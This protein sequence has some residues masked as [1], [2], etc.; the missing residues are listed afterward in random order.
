MFSKKQVQKT[1]DLSFSKS[2]ILK[3]ELIQNE[4][5]HQRLEHARILSLL[6]NLCTDRSLKQQVERYYD[7]Q[8]EILGIHDETSHQTDLDEQQVQ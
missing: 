8:G 7:N 3:L 4:L 2:V 6:E 5:R 1:S